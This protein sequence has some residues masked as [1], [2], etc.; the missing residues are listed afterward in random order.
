MHYVDMKCFLILSKTA[1]FIWKL[2]SQRLFLEKLTLCVTWWYCCVQLQCHTQ[3]RHPC[4]DDQ[5]RKQWMSSW[6]S[7]VTKRN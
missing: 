4:P 5:T 7:L 2:G 3:Q 6:R 1:Y